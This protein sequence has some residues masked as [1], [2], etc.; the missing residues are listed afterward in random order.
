[1]SL[2]FKRRDAEEEGLQGSGRSKEDVGLQR[3]K[4][5]RW[6]IFGFWSADVSILIDAPAVRTTRQ[7]AQP[8][9]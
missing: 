2:E 8:A 7:V 5:G 6:T 1:M 4:R 3:V 9:Y